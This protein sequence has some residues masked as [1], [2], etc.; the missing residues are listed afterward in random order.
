MVVLPGNCLLSPL[1]PS[2]VGD[3]HYH[4]GISMV[5]GDELRFSCLHGK[6]FVEGHPLSPV[7]GT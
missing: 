2:G 7:C 5:V 3:V 6:H 4:A 1:I